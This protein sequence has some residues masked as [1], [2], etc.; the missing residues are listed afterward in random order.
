MT[1]AIY[2]RYS[3][4]NQRPQSIDDQIRNCRAYAARSNLVVSEELIFRDEAI[5]GSLQGRSGLAALHQ[6][7]DNGLVRIVLIDDSSRIFRNNAGFINFI[8]ELRY[9]DV[10]MVSVSEGISTTDENATLNFGVRGIFAQVFLED[11]AKKTHRGQL[12]QALKGSYM[13]GRPYGYKKPVPCGKTFLDSKGR[14]RA[15]SFKLVPDPEQAEIVRLIFKLFVEGKSVNA[16]ARHLNGSNIPTRS[17]LRGGWS[18]GTISGILQ[19]EKYIGKQVWNK[20]KSVKVPKSDKKRAVPRPESEWAVSHDP[21]MRII[22]D[23]TWEAAC[24]R[25]AELNQAFPRGRKGFGKKQKGRATSNPSALLS[26]TLRCGLCGGQLGM[27][28]GSN[29]GYYGCMNARRGTC[30]N[31]VKVRRKVLEE[32]VLDVLRERLK[33][34]EYYEQICREVEEVVRAEAKGIPEEIKLK[35]AV[36]EDA[37]KKLARVL[38]LAEAGG[39]VAETI[40]PRVAELGEA[41][42]SLT[43]EISKLQAMVDEMYVAPPREWIACKL[44][45]LDA[46]LASRV[47]AA[48]LAIRRYFGP[49]T[50]TPKTPEVGKEYFEAKCRVKVLPMTA[51]KR[52]ETSEHDAVAPSDKSATTLE[53]WRWRE[54][55]P[56]PRNLNA[57]F[58]HA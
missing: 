5:S 57:S 29:N 15:E 41:I 47:E 22:D 49:I 14:T 36:L 13:G 9:K 40:A 50:L 44:K 31:N 37:R 32:R 38:E 28:S 43:A 2:A 18:T 34:P 4:E 54:S 56:R 55:N 21:G 42:K 25:W 6:A 53:W 24:K 12:G 48:A 33:Q 17:K 35:T 58:L 20:T 46:L 39:V 52:K 16:I 8:E 7:I 26:G 23:A 45:E 51:E 30:A 1:V 11:L 10:A 3:S 27:V 19:N